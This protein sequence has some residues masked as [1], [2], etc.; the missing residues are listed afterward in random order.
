MVGPLL[1]DLLPVPKLAPIVVELLAGILIGPH[2]LDLVEIDEPVAVLSQIGLVFLFFLAGLEI[3]FDRESGGY[4]WLVAAG[5][6]A[7]IALAVGVAHL[8]E[9]ASMVEAPLLVAIVLAATAFGIV[10]AVLKD[11]H[12]TTTSFGQLVIAGASIADLATVVLLS[13]FF[14][15][16]GSGVES[17]LLLLGLFAILVALVGVALSRARMSTRLLDSIDRLQ[18]TTAQIAVRIA[19]V[20]LAALVFLA[21]E[22]GMEVVLGAFMAGA[23]VS[24][25]DRG[26]AV[27]RTGLKTKLEAIGFGVFVPIFFVASGAQLD[28]DALFASSS[29]AALVAVVPAALLIVRG[30]PALLYRRTVGPR[31]VVAA[32]LLQATSLSFIVPATQ[33]GVELGEISEATAAGLVTGGLVSVLLFPALA[34]GLLEARG[35]TGAGA[36][37]RRRT[38]RSR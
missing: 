30:L 2:V 17:A 33:I 27:E 35:P 29:S 1:I 3:A 23:I 12:Q 6:A 19:F 37:A 5:F 21:E 28:L 36:G 24:L 10:V 32:G 31:Q 9:A 7:S 4:L 26:N 15:H 13:L 18:E 38:A 20:L 14:S 11:A 25:I 34:L 16:Q 8:L 22:L